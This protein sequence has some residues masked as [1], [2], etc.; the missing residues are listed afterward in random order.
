V[1]HHPGHDGAGAVVNSP[2]CRRAGTTTSED[3]R[4]ETVWRACGGSLTYGAF[5]G[6]RPINRG[7]IVM[8]ITMGAWIPVLGWVVWDWSRSAGRRARPW[9]FRRS[10]GILIQ[11]VPDH[12]RRWL[13]VGGPF[14]DERS[15]FAGYQTRTEE[16]VE[17]PADAEHPAG[18]QV[19]DA[20]AVGL[21][22]RAA[23]AEQAERWEPAQSGSD[24]RF[25]IDKEATRCTRAA[26]T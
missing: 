12:R 15:A 9:R 26:V 3:R 23:Q 18:E 11:P 13:E 16:G 22:V 4:A 1:G 8:A 21:Q 17:E 6:G 10:L 20:P 5:G 14:G 24:P 19:D 7:D 25:G 2:G